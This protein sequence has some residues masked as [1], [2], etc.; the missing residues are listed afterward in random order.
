[1]ADSDNA[2]PGKDENTWDAETPETA[3]AAAPAA[4]PERIAELEAEV[5]KLKDQVLRSLAEQENLRRRTT[6][7]R[8]DALRYAV[9]GFAKDLLSVADN[10]RRAIESVP[11]AQIDNEV[12]RTLLTGVEATE[13]ELL[14]AFEKHS[15]RRIDPKGEKFDHN[16]HQAIMELENTGQ[17]AGTIVQVLQA[18]YLLHDRLLREAMV[19]VAKGGAP[20]AA[21]PVQP[22]SGQVAPGQPAPGQPASDP[23]DAGD[24]VHHIDTT[25]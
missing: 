14:G 4:G 24:P 25:A 21:E 3:G 1:M 5:A 2:A 11:E 15:V 6:R 8:E 7:E 10:L 16:L 19:T 13:R 20:A 18:G 12:L 22:A 9:G 23:S 17:P